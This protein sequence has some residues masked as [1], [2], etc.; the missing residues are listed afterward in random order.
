MK[1][2]I[3]ALICIFSLSIWSQRDDTVLEAIETQFETGLI[4]DELSNDEIQEVLYIHAMAYYVNGINFARSQGITPAAYGT[5]LGNQFLPYWDKD[6]EFISFTNKMI[7][8][9]KGFHYNNEIQI[10]SNGDQKIFILIDNVDHL[11]KNG[12]FYDVSYSE[13]LQ[14]SNGLFRKITDHVGIDFSQKITE[15]NRYQLMFSK[16]NKHL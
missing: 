16:K 15:D 1:N 13:F 12:H 6:I 11:F 7:H 5:F 2:L 4:I 14:C 8:I 9:L 10:V 3:F